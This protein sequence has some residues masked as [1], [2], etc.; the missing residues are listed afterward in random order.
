MGLL[1]FFYF[2][3][4]SH[5]EENCYWNNRRN[6]NYSDVEKKYLHRMRENE[7]R[8]R[9]REVGEKDMLKSYD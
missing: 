1:T 6:L 9:E 7:K 5:A 8:Q 4:L 3:L 2:F